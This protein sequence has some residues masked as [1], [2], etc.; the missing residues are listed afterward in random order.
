[1]SDIQNH[2]SAA[3]QLD[4][5]QST[6]P[7]GACDASLDR[8]AIDSC[9]TELA[10]AF[11]TEGRQRQVLDLMCPQERCPHEIAVHRSLHL[12]LL[13]F[14]SQLFRLDQPRGF[15][16]AVELRTDLAAYGTNRFPGFVSF[17]PGPGGATLPQNAS[18][19]S[20]DSRESLTQVL[21]M[22]QS[23]LGDQGQRRLTGIRR[24]Q[25]STQAHL[26]DGHVHLL[27]GK[28]QK[29]RCCHGFEVCR[30]VAESPCGVFNHPRQGATEELRRNG[31]PI[32]SNPLRDLLEMWRGIETG[33]IASR[34]SNGGELNCGGAFAV[35]TR[36]QNRRKARLWVSE[37]RQHLVSGL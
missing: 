5:L 28:N 10:E 18:L 6:R 33:S 35:R 17:Y 4:S 27:F 32:D 21:A 7:V 8:L 12:D 34:R 11:G 30:K 24:V 1:M 29:R 26:H 13:P 16:P 25:S 20:R 2:R 36:D 22:L 15:R 37:A 23:D 3:R 31:G 14:P 9:P 19:L